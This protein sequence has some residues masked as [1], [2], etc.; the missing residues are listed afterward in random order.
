MMPEKY[1]AESLVDAMTGEDLN[2]K[3][4]LIPSAAVTRDVIPKEL[5]QRGALVEVVEAYRNVIAVEAA[6]AKKVFQE[7]YPDWV[8]FASSSAVDRLVDLIGTEPLHRGKIASIGP[9]TSEAVHRHGLTITA[10]ARTP[11]VQGLIEAICKHNT[12]SGVLHQSRAPR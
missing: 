7:P 12:S 11:G 9:V 6:E 2:G 5:R 3:R 1:V 8:T 10:E 4:V